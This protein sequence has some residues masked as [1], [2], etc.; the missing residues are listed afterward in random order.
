MIHKIIL[1]D[2]IN[3]LYQIIVGVVADE[4]SALAVGKQ[5]R[6]AYFHSGSGF[7]SLCV[8]VMQAASSWLR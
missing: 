8:F 3:A 1:C 5:L 2:V 6:I 4:N 7:N